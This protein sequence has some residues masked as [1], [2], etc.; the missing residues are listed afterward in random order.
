MSVYVH[1]KGHSQTVQIGDFVKKGQIIALSGNTG[2][3]TGP[4]LHFAI[5]T[6]TQQGVR[7]IKFR[8]GGVEPLSGTYLSN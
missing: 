7:S 3:T 2:Y 5:Q 6:N 4:H 1:L 8:F